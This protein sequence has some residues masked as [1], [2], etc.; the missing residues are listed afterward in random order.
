VRRRLAL[1]F[2]AVLCLAPAS[3]HA[4]VNQLFSHTPRPMSLGGAYTAVA[5]DASA[6]YYNPAG[7]TE[8]DGSFIE[9]AFLF[10]FP[11]FGA[12]RSDGMRPDL[13]P[14]S[15]D[16]YGLH[17]AWSPRSILDGNLG[18]GFS[19]L[20][21]H[22]KALHFV[23][24]R[25]EDPYFVLYENSVELLEIR[26]GAAYKILD[27]VSIGFS[28]L[29][30]AGLDGKVV[31]EAPFQATS[32]I[33]SSKRTVVAVDALLP[34]RQFF[35]A[36]AQ[37]FPL[38]GLRFGVSYREAT[39]VPIRL[40]IDFTVEILG[41][42][43]IRTVAD[44]DVKVKYSPAQLTF[45]GAWEVTPDLMI[46]ADVAYAFYSKYQIPY[47]N[48]TLERKFSPDITLLPPKQ[49]QT[50]LRDVIIP[51]VGAEYRLAESFTIRA[52]YYFFRSFIKSSDAPI[53][54]SDKH[55]ITAGLSY[56]LGK[57]FLPQG[58]E[59]DLIGAGQLVLFTS[60]HTADY[61]HSGQV[62]STSFG[63][64]FTY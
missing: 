63:A 53:F 20:L 33:D 21:P 61:S 57:L 2:V 35:T 17:L 44:L 45:G 25:F 22:R 10:T 47:G 26:V 19:L 24:H 36:G 34:N 4:D 40:P 28:G 1:A 27:L 38:K 30:L 43:P 11:N 51:R 56:A 3:A 18:L 62:F 41:L 50:E 54:D 55:G 5:N 39:F 14:P 16:S 31:L 49:P 64:Q 59:L 29:L 13:S 8:V 48:V 6:L 60:R 32:D 15:D 7:L 58:T 23:V 52:G 42:T 12:T 37:I 46:T 9:L